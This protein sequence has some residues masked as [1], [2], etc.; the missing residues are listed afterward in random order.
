MDEGE[1]IELPGFEAFA[2]QLRSDGLAPCDGE[3]LG[4]EAAAF[5]DIEPFVGK[6]PAA[7][8]EDFFGNEIAE[9]SFHR[10]PGGRG[11][12]E[13]PGRGPE[14]LAEAGLD[15][16]VEILELAA[17]MPDH[18]LGHGRE[19]LGGNLDGAGDEELDVVAHGNQGRNQGKRAGN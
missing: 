19:G 7:A 17:A 16:A 8:V 6:G 5:G 18:G 10:P 11:G 3:E 2:H 4:I 12:E 15:G 14:E 9:A 1:G 13:D